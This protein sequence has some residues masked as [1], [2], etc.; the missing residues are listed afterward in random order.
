MQISTPKYF[1]LNICFYICA[2]YL[3]FYILH[4]VF[5][6]VLFL[7]RINRNSLLHKIILLHFEI[8]FV[9]EVCLLDDPYFLV[10]TRGSSSVSLGVREEDYDI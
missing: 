7:Y 5:Y 6:V 10:E 8:N 3:Q 9:C 1:N 2:L 4:A